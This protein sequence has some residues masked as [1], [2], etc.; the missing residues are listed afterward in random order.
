MADVVFTSAKVMRSDAFIASTHWADPSGPR[1]VMTTMAFWQFGPFENAS[2][3]CGLC[4]AGTQTEP[5]DA[6]HP[7]AATAPPVIADGTTTPA[8][9]ATATAKA[10]IHEVRFA[11]I[12]S[13][14]RINSDIDRT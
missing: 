6:S 5:T 8:R 4:R 9:P 1:T 11:I 13:L 10:I 14:T 7:P 3:L 2:A 12:V